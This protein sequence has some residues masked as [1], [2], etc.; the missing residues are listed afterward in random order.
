MSAGPRVP[1]L[2]PGG[3]GT[4]RHVRV[5]L[6]D[7][8]EMA[9]LGLGAM[10]RT[11]DWVE[12]VGDAD[13]YDAGMAMIER[14]RPDVVLLDVRTPGADGFA[15]LDAIRALEPSIAVVIVTL[16]EDPRAVLDAVSRGASGYLLKDASTS[17]V[18][19]TLASVASGQLAIEPGLLREA[20]ALSQ[21]AR[22]D[23]T[24]AA[25]AEAWSLTPREFEVLRLVADGL[26]NKE[27]GARLFLSPKT[28]EFHLGRAYRKLAVRSRAELIKLFAQESAAVERLKV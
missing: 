23:R 5:V 1:D 26:T 7:G 25:R 13:T 2:M 21:E 17:S 12:L 20:L 16:D 28:V 27:I 8:H 14:E 3:N 10:L 15:S 22:A 4:S 9:R 6:V 24:P 19:A 18:L 11:A